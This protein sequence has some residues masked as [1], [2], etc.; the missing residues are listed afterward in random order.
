MRKYVSVGRWGIHRLVVIA[1]AVLILTTAYAI[2]YMTKTID[3]TA[4]VKVSGNIALYSDEACTIPFSGS[5]D[6]PLFDTE[7]QQFE[8]NVWMKNVGNVDVKVYWN[9]STSSIVWT[10]AEDGSYMHNKSGVDY[11]KTWMRLFPQ[12]EVWTPNTMNVTL[13]KGAV[14]KLQFN[15]FCYKIDIPETFTYTA[16]IASKDA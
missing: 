14:Q 8:C 10:I 11:Y 7:N 6:Y 2:V 12:D 5:F 16:L 4:G 13:S 9:M 1:I 3:F 15:I